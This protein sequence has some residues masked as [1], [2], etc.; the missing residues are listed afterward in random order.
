MACKVLSH[1]AIESRS[2][3]SN[4]STRR[5]LLVGRSLLYNVHGA[6][7]LWLENVWSNRLLVSGLFGVKVSGVKN[8]GF[9]AK[10]FSGVKTLWRELP[11]L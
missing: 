1:F 5:S 8:E 9:G 11:V 3:Q 10:G 2:L 4:E 6:A 7:I